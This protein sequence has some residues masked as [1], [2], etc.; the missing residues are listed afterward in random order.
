MDQHRA[1]RVSETVREELGPD[2]DF[3]IECHWRYD[4]R[5]VIELAKALEHVKPMWLEDPVPPENPEAMARVTHAVDVPICTGENLY[6]RHGFRKLIELQACDAV[7]IDIPKSGGL[8]ESKRI[9][10]MA[11]LYYIW[12]AAHN[13]ASPLGTIASAHAASSMRSFRIHELAKEQSV[14]ARICG[15]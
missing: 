7:H 12:T 3:A 13:P 10:D 5:D 14:D 11:D 8:L 9:S 1:E 4:V 15:R 2:V 6:T